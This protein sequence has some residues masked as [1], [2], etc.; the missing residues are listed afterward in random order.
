MIR[1]G[2]TRF[3]VLETRKLGFSQR[4]SLMPLNFPQITEIPAT[5]GIF[6]YFEFYHNP[7]WISSPEPQR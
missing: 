5:Y 4:P 7:G 2:C 3:G 6:D 1:P